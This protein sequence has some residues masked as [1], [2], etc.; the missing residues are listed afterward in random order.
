MNTFWIKLLN[1]LLVIAVILGYNGILHSRGQAETIAQLEFELE[2][3]QQVDL[4]QEQ[5]SKTDSKYQDGVYEG[6]AKGFGGPIVMQAVIEDGKLTE[7]NIVSADKEDEAYLNAA[8]TLIDNILEVQ[9]ADV[10]V[11]SGATFSSNGII[12]ATTEALRKAEEAT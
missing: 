10:D 2:K 1:S 5:T 6:E 8:S 9:S 7:L 3:Q 11:I 4:E 12:E